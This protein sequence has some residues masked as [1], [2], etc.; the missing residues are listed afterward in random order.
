M[1]KYGHYIALGLSILGLILAGISGTMA[2]RASH[3]PTIEAAP[4]A[5]VEAEPTPEVE[6]T[7]EVTE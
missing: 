2:W 3:T 4:T 7:A 1:K 6:S 5:I